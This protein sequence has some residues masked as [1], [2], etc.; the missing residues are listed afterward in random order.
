MKLFDEFIKK[1][2][3]K[4][5]KKEQFIINAKVIEGKKGNKKYQ[6]F[7]IETKEGDWKINLNGVDLHCD[8]FT[9]ME[10]KI[11]KHYKL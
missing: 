1:Q 7:L 5:R 10:N 4:L 8:E 9:S 3:K 11:K 2:Y 6:V